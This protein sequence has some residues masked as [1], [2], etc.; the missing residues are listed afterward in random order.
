MCILVSFCWKTRKVSRAV[1]WKLL[2][3]SDW[4]FFSLSFFCSSALATRQLLIEGNQIQRAEKI[5]KTQ[6]TEL[7]TNIFIQPSWSYSLWVD[8][9]K[10]KALNKKELSHFTLIIG[11]NFIID[12]VSTPK[13]VSSPQ[14]KRYNDSGSDSTYNT[15][16]NICHVNAINFHNDN[17][18]SLFF[19]LLQSRLF[20]MKID[21]F[22]HPPRCVCYWMSKFR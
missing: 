14:H 12:F 2:F 6:A 7:C 1:H 19:W 10:K 11:E 13:H 16:P 22:L 17:R 3:H 20:S 5:P 8:T 21:F 18:F 9:L 15:I 4:K